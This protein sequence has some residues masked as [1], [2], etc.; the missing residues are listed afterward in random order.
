MTVLNFESDLQIQAESRQ[1]D[2]D[3]LYFRGLRSLLRR[4]LPASLDSEIVPAFIRRTVLRLLGCDLAINVCIWPKM[5]L[6][7]LQRVD[8]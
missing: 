5:R 2:R 8:G 6:P 4:I 3:S 7:I 1:G